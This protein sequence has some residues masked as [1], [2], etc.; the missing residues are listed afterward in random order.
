MIFKC[1]KI[2]LFL[3][4]FWQVI[5]FLLRYTLLKKTRKEISFYEKQITCTYRNPFN[6]LLW[7]FP[8]RLLSPV[9]R[10]ICYL[11]E[12]SPC[13]WK[14]CLQGDTV[15]FYQS[16]VKMAI[17]RPKKH[18]KPERKITTKK[19]FTTFAFRT[20]IM[21]IYFIITKRWW[22]QYDA[23]CIRE[24]CH[25]LKALLQKTSE[26]QLWAAP[27]RPGDSVIIVNEVCF[28]R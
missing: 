26:D 17:Y 10:K 23:D 9:S 5:Y 24:K 13:R 6:L 21:K 25:G 22:D 28:C 11:T 14:P 3:F 27:I 18:K 15:I 20:T 1:C 2:C 16:D 12:E 8:V 4:P 7:L 19:L